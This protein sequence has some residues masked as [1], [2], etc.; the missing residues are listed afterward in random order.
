VTVVTFSWYI[1]KTQGTSM[2]YPITTGV[3][4]AF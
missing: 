4:N 2:V 1:T 3:V